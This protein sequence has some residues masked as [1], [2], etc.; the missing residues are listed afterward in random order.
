VG[1]FGGYFKL[2]HYPRLRSLRS[3]LSLNTPTTLLSLL[4]VKGWDA[5]GDWVDAAEEGR[6]A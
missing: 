4:T 2:S 1:A 6:V 3:Q 5:A